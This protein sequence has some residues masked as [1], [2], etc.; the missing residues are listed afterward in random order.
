M[1]LL[2][3]VTMPNVKWGSPTARV[4]SI[5]S[6][7]GAAMLFVCLAHF[8]NTYFFLNGHD[9]AGA[10]LVSIGMIASPTFVT[11]SGLVA[12][13]LAITRKKSFTSLQRK[14]FDRG[15]FLLLVGHVILALSGV[16]T[17][18]GFLTAYK[19]GYITDAIGF[20]V[21][22]GPWLVTALQPGSRIILA[23]VVFA[24]NWVAVLFWNP[25]GSAASLIKHYW[26]GHLN[27]ADWGSTA[28]DFALIPWFAVYLV[29]TTI[30]E[31][32]GRHYLAK[33]EHL[34]HLL[35]VKIGAVCIGLALGVKFVLVA[36]RQTVPL[37]AQAHPDLL[38]FLSFYQK[39]PPGPMYLLFFT[40]A[41]MLLVAAVLEAGRRGIQPFL[42]GQL[43][44]IG[45]ASLFVYVIQYYVYAVALRALHLPYSQFWPILFALS[46]VLLAIAAKLW[47]SVDGNRFL[48]VGVGPILDW[49]AR[50]KNDRH[51]SRI[52]ADARAT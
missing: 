15:L 16:L 46:I 10:Y 8:T 17:G 45:L 24:L 28:G 44:Q 41:G 3:G 48:T 18:R 52:A 23:A 2:C 26:V 39:F 37:F 11:V 32:V 30:G 20:A 22:L 35:L 42:L 25:V 12:G 6:A 29:G 40:G 34:G 49:S 33:N 47:N 14:L 51:A 21:L 4:A 19:V 7:R 43:R 5:D 50:R 27:L 9:E 38:N 13:F 1:P 31:R 36:L